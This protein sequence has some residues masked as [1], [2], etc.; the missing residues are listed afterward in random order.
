MSSPFQRDLCHYN[1]LY[2]DG[3]HPRSTVVAMYAGFTC[4]CIHCVSVGLAAMPTCTYTAC[5][6]WTVSV[7]VGY[8]IAALSIY[9]VIVNVQGMHRQRR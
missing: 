3:N 5:G 8:K 7:I 1:E 2:I 9:I 6:C 4:Y